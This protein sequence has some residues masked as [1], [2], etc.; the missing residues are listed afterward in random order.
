MG[1]GITRGV[2]ERV[3]LVT[4]GMGGVPQVVIESIQQSIRPRVGQSGTK[5]RLQEL[6]EVI[7]WAKLVE[8][9]RRPP[10]QKVSGSVRVMVL[11]DEGRDRVVVEHLQSRVKRAW[12]D[13][14][15]V[16][17]RLR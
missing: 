6:Q 12:E 1:L 17:R 16:I 14:K 5:R 10:A 2:P 8:L 11:A 9:N 13:I 4:M 15:I 7:V 3:G